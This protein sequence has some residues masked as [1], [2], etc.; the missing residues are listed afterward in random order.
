MAAIIGLSFVS[1]TT[2]AA[3][4]PTIQSTFDATHWILP[5]GTAVT[6][7][8]GFPLGLLT[9]SD[10]EALPA[11]R[12]VVFADG[13]I[14]FDVSSIDHAM[15]IPGVRF[16][17]D[18]NHNGEEFY[19]RTMPDCPAENDC[20]QYTPVVHGNLL[21]N[22][23]PQYQSGADVRPGW[24][25]VRVV[26]SGGRMAAFVNEA[27]RPAIVVDALQGDTHA[28]GIELEGQGRFANVTVRPN[29]IADLPPQVPIEASV[30][31]WLD[32]W[33]V[34][35]P[36]ALPGG[37]EPTAAPIAGA[38]PFTPIPSEPGGLVNLARRYG[39]P[40]D[41]QVATVWL[42]SGID[43]TTD[44]T[45]HADLGWLGDVWVFV[46]GAPVFSGKNLYAST[47]QFPD[48]RLDPSNGHVTLPLRRGHNTV[49]V[50]IDNRWKAGGSR[51]GWGMTMRL[52]DT[53]KL[54]FPRF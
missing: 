6:Y 32:A 34:T 29:E 42:S 12:D 30:S 52:T 45:V 49:V 51:Y 17:T 20:V 24:N 27:P 33:Q 41:G 26:V 11:L 38:L 7:P 10:Q 5:K 8:E 15:S 14:E 48:G 16:R 54:A 40:L 31:H 43:A 35:S 37:A 1:L 4:N 21:W 18:A 22:M 46:N 23:Y 13:T 53:E 2:M 39:K 9:I 44:T 25:H 28:G 50:A 3:P 36:V 47:R 19:I